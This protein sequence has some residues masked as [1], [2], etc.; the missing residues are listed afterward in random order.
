MHEEEAILCKEEKAIL[1]DYVRWATSENLAQTHD[2]VDVTA[3]WNGGQATS[4][5]MLAIVRHLGMQRHGEMQQCSLARRML[6]GR[7]SFSL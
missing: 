5:Q 4:N 7:Q 6:I 2:G 1:F 3:E